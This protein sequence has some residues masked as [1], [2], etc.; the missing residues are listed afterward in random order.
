MFDWHRFLPN[1]LSSR[2]FVDP[3]WLEALLE[4]RL[5]RARL[6]N[7]RPAM[8]SAERRQWKVNVTCPGRRECGDPSFLVTQSPTSLQDYG[9]LSAFPIHR[10]C[11]DNPRFTVQMARNGILADSLLQQS[12]NAQA[13]IKPCKLCHRIGT[14]NRLR[15]PSPMTWLAKPDNFQWLIIIGMV[16]V[17]PVLAMWSDCFGSAADFAWFWRQFTSF[18]GFL[19]QVICVLILHLVLQNQSW[20]TFGSSQK[21]KLD[22]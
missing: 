15:S 14:R 3:C 9:K 20:N 8:S 2:T 6:G 11:R 5:K 1:I 22:G 7:S 10:G 17:N 18:N 12:F 21:S 19:D 4:K 13:F 16:S